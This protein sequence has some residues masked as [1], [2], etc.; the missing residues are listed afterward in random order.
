MIP[1][2]Y[3]TTATIHAPVARVWAILTDAD[4]YRTWNPEIIAIVGR[5]AP[6][7][8]FT[9]RVKL[10]NGAVRSISMRVTAFDPPS[11]IEWT[12]GLPF[13]LFVGRRTFTVAPHAA[14]CQFRMDLRMTGLVA[15]LIIR[16]V[17][18]RQSEIDLFASALKTCAESS[19]L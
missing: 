19:A 12:G 9:A 15:P 16:S 17:G 2:E 7:E 8:R 14:G 11:T 4:G 13:G 5:F 3:V 18:N 6:G 10:G 1:S